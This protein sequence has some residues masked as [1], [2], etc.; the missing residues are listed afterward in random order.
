MSVVDFSNALTP[1]EEIQLTVT[2]PASGRN[3][4]AGLVRSGRSH[5]VPAA[6]EGL[7]HAVVQEGAE[8]AEHPS[9]R[10]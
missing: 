6:G 2:D 7:G 4:A 10:Q 9:R 3:H 1:T 8:S 5:P